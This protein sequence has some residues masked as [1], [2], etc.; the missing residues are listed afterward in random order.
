VTDCPPDEVHR[1]TCLPPE[2][3]AAGRLLGRAEKTLASWLVE[4]DDRKLCRDFSCSS[5]F[6][7]AARF[8]KLAGHTAAEYLRTGRKLAELP[9]L[10]ASYERGEISGT[11]IREITRAATAETESFWHKAARNC[12]TREIEKMVA[13]TPRGGLPP[14]KTQEAPS[15]PLFQETTSAPGNGTEEHTCQLDAGASVSCQP[16]P[17]SAPGMKAW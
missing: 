11:Q 5:I 7:Y 4:I 14:V 8:L 6:H 3:G 10:S 2:G 13:F 15:L 12:T 1:R 16:T 9:L 17:V